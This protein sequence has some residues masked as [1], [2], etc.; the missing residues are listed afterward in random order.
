M[1]RSPSRLEECNI[2]VNYPHLAPNLDLLNF[3]LQKSF[4]VKI[5]YDRPRSSIFSKSNLKANESLLDLQAR[6]LRQHTFLDLCKHLIHLAVEST[7]LLAVKRSNDTFFLD[8]HTFSQHVKMHFHK[9]RF[10]WIFCGFLA[11]LEIRSQCS[12]VSLSKP[13]F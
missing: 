13:L 2:Y 1:A 5:G 8:P 12:S 9:T 6:N 7:Y 11:T 4:S 3:G 10:N